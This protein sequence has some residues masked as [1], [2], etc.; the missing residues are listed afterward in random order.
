MKKLFALLTISAIIT[1]CSTDPTNIDVNELEEPC[2][3]LEALS[4]N[5]KA[6]IQL[7]EDNDD[8]KH[9]D[10]KKADKKKLKQLVKS[11]NKIVKKMKE[12]IEDDFDDDKG[13]FDDE[14]EE[15]ENFDEMEDLK[16]DLQEA[17]EDEDVFDGVTRIE[18]SKGV[19]LCEC[20]GMSSMDIEACQMM[21][22]A[23]EKLNKDDKYLID[24]RIEECHKH[25]D[26]DDGMDVQPNYN[27]VH[28]DEHHQ[29]E[30]EAPAEYYDEYEEDEYY[31]EPYEEELRVEYGI[32]SSTSSILPPFENY[33]YEGYKVHDSNLNT[34]W[35]PKNSDK[36]PSITIN[37]N[38]WQYLKG[39]EIHGGAHFENFVSRNGTNFG[40]LYLKNQRVKE[41]KIVFSDGVTQYF[42]LDDMDRIQEIIFEESHYVNSFTLYVTDVYKSNKWDDICISH[43]MPLVSY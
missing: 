33:T 18:I 37:F 3:F 30:V 6:Q 17:F 24:E 43:L 10:W 20:L 14:M 35:S 7:I 22:N 40:N 31:D 42:Y 5:Y 32:S 19:S 26:K 25:K 2:D 8:E 29:T 15:C 11:K 4:D 36:S 12:V 27:E 38:D 16:D 34:W 41:F 23:Y 9:E 28:A 21:F 13:D 1:S 39:I